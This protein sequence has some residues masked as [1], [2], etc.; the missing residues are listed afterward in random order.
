[1]ILRPS[2]ETSSQGDEDEWDFGKAFVNQHE[3]EFGF[4]LP[5]RDIII[6]DVRVRGTGKTFHGLAKTVDQ[7]LNASS[8][9]IARVKNVSDARY[10]LKE[11]DS[12]L[13]YTSSPIWLS[14][15]ALKDQRLSSTIPRP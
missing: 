12:K 9:T 5:D 13:Q 4:T 15:I 10:T 6:D 1:M 14:M 8:P 7:Q 2:K 3:Q 11:A